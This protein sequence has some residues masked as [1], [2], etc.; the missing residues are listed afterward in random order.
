MGKPVSSSTDT[1]RFPGRSMT[2]AGT[3]GSGARMEVTRFGPLSLREKT[4]VRQTR[5]A[6]VTQIRSARATL[7]P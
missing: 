3:G 4:N 6:K 1:I 2:D 5:V 7:G